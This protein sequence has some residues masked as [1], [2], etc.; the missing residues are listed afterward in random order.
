LSQNDIYSNNEI[1]L[2]LKCSRAQIDA[3]RIQEIKDVLDKGIDW[4]IIFNLASSQ[5][6]LPL[7]YRNLRLTFP[8]AIPPDIVTRLANVYHINARKNWMLARE[9]LRIV[10]NFNFRNVSIVP[11]KGPIL[12]E[13]IYGD[14]ALRNFADLDFLIPQNQLH[15]ADELLQALGYIRERQTTPA[16]E[17]F[18]LK[19]EHHYEFINRENG[20]LV[21]IHWKVSPNI[22]FLQPEITSFWDQLQPIAFF[23]KKVLSFPSEVMLQILCEHGTRHKWSRLS[24][25]C[26]VAGL[27]ETKKP[28]LMSM[29]GRSK[30]LRN[31]RPLLLGLYLA[32][33][34]L[35]AQISK[36]IYNL[37]NADQ[38]VRENAIKVKGALFETML[39]YGG[40][41]DH[42]PMQQSNEFGF[43]LNLIEMRKIRQIM[44]HAITPRDKDWNTIQLPDRLIPL[45]YLIRPIRLI[46][47]YKKE[48]MERF[49]RPKT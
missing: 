19:T 9:M 40:N 23:G 20:V 2:L 13:Q 33:D 45:Y 12:A 26:D 47:A 46:N 49:I 36:E 11:Y 14:V 29:I 21:E 32:K 17:E 15:E 25:I 37:A 30:E 38:G 5:R 41:I 43:Y 4:N 10:D 44:Q 22:F 8:E 35:D 18:F 24:W 48:L 39:S 34:L 28:D 16:R 31:R 42:L 7:F 1:N 6:M 3:E 27:I